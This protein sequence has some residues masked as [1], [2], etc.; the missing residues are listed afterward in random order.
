MSAPSFSSFPAPS[1]SSFPET[2]EP[3]DKKK[4]KDKEKNKSE[5]KHSSKDKDK[6]K[7]RKDRDR[8]S[9][10]EPDHDREKSR[11][12]DERERDRGKEKDKKS[13]TKDKDAEKAYREEKRKERK[14]RDKKKEKRKHSGDDDK[15]ADSDLEQGDAYDFERDL[16]N[17][18]KQRRAVEESDHG[19][20]DLS[21][22]CITDREGDPGNIQYGSL[23]R[24]DVP[25]FFRAGYGNVLGAPPGWKIV[26]RGV[27]KTVEIGKRGR[28]AA[29][30]Y[31]DKRAISTTTRRLVPSK[32]VLP[33]TKEEEEEGYVRI[34]KRRSPN[35]EDDMADEMDEAGKARRREDGPAYRAITRDD[36]DSSASSASSSESESD[37]ELVTP[38]LTR[39][40]YLSARVRDHPTDIQAWLALLKHNTT[41]APNALARAEIA[42]SVLAKA[43]AAHPANRQSSSLRLRSLRAGEMVWPE[44]QLEQEWNATLKDFPQNG[45]V[46]SEWVGWRMRAMDSVETVIQD[47]RHAMNILQGT[48]DDLEMQ[49]LRIFWRACVWLRQAGYVE[50]AIAAMQAQIE[51]TFFP[52]RDRPATFADTIAKFEEFWDSEAPRLGEVGA[53]G[54]GV[55]AEDPTTESIPESDPVIPPLQESPTDPYRLWSQREANLDNALKHP[56]RLRPAN[57]YLDDPYRIV[58][59]SDFSSLLT[60]L[61]TPIA[62][63]N[64][65]FVFLHFLGLHTPGS[66]PPPDDIWADDRWMNRENLLFP[67]E[68]KSA[69][70]LVLD[71]GALI[72]R[73]RM[74]RA[75]WGPVK[76]W[77][78]GVGRITG[79][80]SDR[81]IGGRTWESDDLHGVDADFVSRIFAVLSPVV[82]DE[83]WDEHWLAFEAVTNPKKALK[84]SRSQLAH[85]Q[86]SLYRWAAHAR[87]ERARDKPDEARKIY[88]VN[89]AQ[90][91]L[92]K[93]RP[94]ELELWWDWAELEWLRDEVDSALQVLVIAV[95]VS[96]I[97]S[98]DILRAKRAYDAAL[99][100]S[101]SQ[102]PAANI[103]LVKLRALL[104][105]LTSGSLPGAL[106]IFNR[107][108]QS[109]QFLPYTTEHE[110]LTLAATSTAFHHTRTLQRPCPPSVFREQAT[111]AIKL[112]PGNTTLL[113]LFLESE[114]GE[115]IWGRVR[116]AVSD[117]VLHEDLKDDI[118]TEVSLT[119][120][121]W[122]VWV[123]SWEHGHYEIERVR[124]VL[125]RAVND[126]RMRHSPSVWRIYL[127]L[128][129]RAGK[130][131]RA[132]A[133]L[134][135]AVASCP[136]V[137]DFYMLA[138]GRLRA[139][140]TSAQ[141]NQ[142][143]NLMAE[144]QIRTRTDIEEL[145]V[146]WVSERDSDS[147]SEEGGEME[148]EEK[149]QELRRLMPY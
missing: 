141:L 129:L 115:K 84:L 9:R 56:L 140:F 81:M 147:G 47:I 99:D 110:A 98:V 4:E 82:Q 3:K 5:K 10:H 36:R 94:G 13:R 105:L 91:N 54:W 114:R 37:T 21:S 1:F 102:D 119:R 135:Q 46:W 116:A 117:I 42:A 125:T 32:T 131:D 97:S 133:L 39:A 69:G 93:R 44:Q 95:G 146:N 64:L 45:D 55:W 38:E 61:I 48:T 106:A 138:F 72:G 142:W 53:R 59:L 17:A 31:V 75:G 12:H 49:R 83:M 27:S 40:G 100:H 130:L 109:P 92:D 127:E 111:A 77:G 80:E 63:R 136:W 71:G 68:L 132:K 112:Y 73:E 108:L 30:R 41:P 144:R 51:I 145:L 124:T 14:G 120:V 33:L 15:D 67:E 20:L 29:K 121:L 126:H 35:Y 22:L 137:K 43:L 34:S 16:E 104:E 70:P 134:F 143:T 11:H 23:H 103:A 79:A 25:R 62:R 90:T 52:L 60:P 66:T 113:G 58:V 78:W 96:D 128:E 2:E 86:S 65:L 118:K 101:A 57:Y 88:R 148:I 24:G 139:V 122:A 19:S 18:R 149:A 50:R 87:L 7:E 6:D 8:T 28:P 123:E 85:D 26:G 76:E 89:L 74:L 107:Q